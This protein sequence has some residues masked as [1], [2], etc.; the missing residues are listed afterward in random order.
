[1]PEPNYNAMAR[2]LE[3][4][5]FYSPDQPTT[6]APRSLYQPL[7][8]QQLYPGSTAAPNYSPYPT[9]VGGLRIPLDQNTDVTARGFYQHMPREWNAPPAYGGMF[10]ISRRF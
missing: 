1:M 8:P 7:A 10:G 4:L 2:M 3:Y 9:V 6:Q 5:G